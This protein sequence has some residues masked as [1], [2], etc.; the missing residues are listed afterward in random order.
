MLKL[1]KILL[2]LTLA[3]LQ[4]E[5]SVGQPLTSSPLLQSL[6]NKIQERRNYETNNYQPP[7]F[8]NPA[9]NPT[10]S[11]PNTNLYKVN[12]NNNNIITKYNSNAFTNNNVYAY[13]LNRLRIK[14]QRSD[15]GQVDLNRKSPGPAHVWK[16][17]WN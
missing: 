8:K 15:F 16:Y 3:L 2:A 11:Q 14:R 10:Q 6:V 1:N 13:I 5:L 7:V 12:D 17:T 9:N 4:I